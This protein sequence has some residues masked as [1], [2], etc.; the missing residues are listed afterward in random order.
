M[1]NKLR[2]DGKGIRVQ[3]YTLTLLRG[4]L[5]YAV[6]W[7]FLETSPAEHVDMPTGHAEEKIA[8]TA[9]QARTFLAVIRHDRLYSLY[10]AFILGGL[11]RAE[12]LG[13][14]VDAVN[15][16]ELWLEVRH[17]VVY[18][19][20]KKLERDKTKTP[21]GRRCFAISQAF[22]DLIAARLF[23]RDL[24]RTAAGASWQESGYIWTDETGG[25]FH[26]RDLRKH[27]AEVV[28]EAGVPPITFR[29]MRHTYLSLL[30]RRGVNAKVAQHR[31]GHADVMT[32]LNV[33]T[34]HYDDEDRLAA[35]VLDD[36][37]EERPKP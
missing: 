31:A 3:Q 17:T 34:H 33:Y 13:L 30:N 4:A 23:E 37:L 32:T 22:A 16:S 1:L 10:A 24:E 5:R 11:R 2:A 12:V 18:S 35:S 20:G 25:S 7:K 27:Y 9:E 15:L 28:K 19:N 6:R 21:K 14:K 26:E 29:E 36:L 8:W